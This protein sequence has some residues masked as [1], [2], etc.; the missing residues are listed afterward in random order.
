MCCARAVHRVHDS[1]RQLILPLHSPSPPQITNP[2]YAEQSLQVSP[3]VAFGPGLCVREHT[4]SQAGH[5]PFVA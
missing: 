4:G 5:R 1:P 2:E 3:V